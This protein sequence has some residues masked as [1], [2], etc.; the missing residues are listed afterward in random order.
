ML[1]QN[2]AYLGMDDYYLNAKLSVV[3]CTAKNP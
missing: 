3:S 2:A 1:L